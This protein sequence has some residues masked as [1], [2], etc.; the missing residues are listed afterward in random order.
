MKLQLTTRKVETLLPAFLFKTS[1]YETG[2]ETVAFAGLMVP[3]GLLTL[4]SA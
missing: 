2:K 3:V 4:I 1:A